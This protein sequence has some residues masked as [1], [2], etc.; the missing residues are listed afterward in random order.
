MKCVSWSAMYFCVDNFFFFNK[1]FL[2]FCIYSWTTT[3]LCV[4]IPKLS[5]I[6]PEFESGTTTQKVSEQCSICIYSHS[7]LVRRDHRRHH[8]K[9][10]NKWVMTLCVTVTHTQGFELITGF[11]NLFC[12]FADLSNKCIP[13][14]NHHR[15]FPFFAFLLLFSSSLYL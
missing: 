4:Q 7:F 3:T 15:A 1:T 6:E 11:R 14:L 9:I 10:P 5:E 12:E 8:P 13:Q 2:V